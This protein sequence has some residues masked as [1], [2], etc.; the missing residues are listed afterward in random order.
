MTCKMCNN[1]LKS[2]EIIWYPEEQRHEDLCSRCRGVVRSDC[3]EA[4]DNVERM[5]KSHPDVE[6]YD[7]S[8]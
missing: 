1:A 3:W 2:S 7:E 5:F 8:I 6:V 4:G